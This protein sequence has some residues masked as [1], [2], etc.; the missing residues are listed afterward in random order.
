MHQLLKHVISNLADR[1]EINWVQVDKEMGIIT[2][3]DREKQL[4]NHLRTIDSVQ[5]VAIARSK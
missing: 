1:K 3:S 5:N 4:I 2:I